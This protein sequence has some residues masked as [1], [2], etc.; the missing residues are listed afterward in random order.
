MIVVQ[1]QGED[2][3]YVLVGSLRV[4]IADAADKAHAAKLGVHFSPVKVLPA[5]DPVWR[6][7]ELTFSGGTP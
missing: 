2:E 5:T 6:W 3:Q 4:H 7:P 1:K